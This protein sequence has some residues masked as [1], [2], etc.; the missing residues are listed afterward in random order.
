[1]PTDNEIILQKAIDDLSDKYSA[2]QEHYVNL[3]VRW[4]ALEADYHEH[5]GYYR[6]KYGE[7]KEE[8]NK[9]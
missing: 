9:K 3:Y 6:D 4:K 1:M 5:I 2:L 8:L 7:L